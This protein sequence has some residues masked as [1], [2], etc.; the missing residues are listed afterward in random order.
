VRGFES[1]PEGLEVIAV[2]GAR[3]EEGDGELVAD[4]WPQADG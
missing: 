2:G 4:R 3:P 1:G